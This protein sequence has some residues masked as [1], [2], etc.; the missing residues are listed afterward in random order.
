MEIV[1]WS[2]YD[3]S[4]ICYQPDNMTLRELQELPTEIMRWFYNPVSSI[5]IFLKTIAFPFDY[6]TR[7][8]Q[9][10]YRGWRN[11]IVKFAGHLLINRWLRHC[12]R[13]P[14][15]EKLEKFVSE[16]RNVDG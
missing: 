16:S 3:G 2:K 14:F 15:L 10:W 6:L 7:G 11:D 8:W 1:P 4:Y 9:E 13:Q 5:R 12:E